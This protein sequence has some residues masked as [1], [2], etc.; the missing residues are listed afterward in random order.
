MFEHPV[1][2]DP[3]G[4]SHDAAYFCV[5]T[6]N[7]SMH[8]TTWTSFDTETREET[9]NNT[10][11]RHITYRISY[12]SSETH[13]NDNRAAM[14]YPNA[15]LSASDPVPQDK[16]MFAFDAGEE[17]NGLSMQDAAIKHFKETVLTAQE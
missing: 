16:M 3:Y 15:S 1:N 2:P 4:N 8:T 12:W 6:C 5:K 11:T 9:G 7:E 13:F 17:Y 14:P 10:V